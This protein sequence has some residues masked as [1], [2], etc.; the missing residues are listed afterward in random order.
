[1]SN[2]KQSNS[3]IQRAEPTSVVRWTKKRLGAYVVET[4]REV[5]TVIGICYR[6]TK[7][8]GKI[9]IR[10][11]SKSPRFSLKAHE[12]SLLERFEWD[13]GEGNLFGLKGVVKKR[14][15]VPSN[16]AAEPS[17]SEELV[18]VPKKENQPRKSSKDDRE[19]LA[20]ENL[21]RAK[22]FEEI[23]QVV[24]IGM[25]ELCTLA[26]RSVASVNRD[27]KN[28][29][30]PLYSVFGETA[31]PESGVP[32]ESKAPKKRG[33]QRKLTLTDAERYRDWLLTK[34]RAA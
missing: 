26:G 13:K 9:E 34:G 20:F 21:K 18:E 24:I 14:T 10:K 25:N 23:G 5:L 19:K 16:Q 31:A 27:L 7:S 11:V 3:N 32:K 22:Q 4:G 15:P 33:P 30:C 29:E 12:Q 2:E 6:L 17:I 8:N 28:K 1:M